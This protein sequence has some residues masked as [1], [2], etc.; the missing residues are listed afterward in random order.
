MI[1]NIINIIIP[2]ITHPS[3]HGRLDNKDLLSMLIV[4]VSLSLPGTVLYFI[5]RIRKKYFLDMFSD[6]SMVCFFTVLGITAIIS[7]MLFVRSIL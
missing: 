2:V 1:N 7:L 6:M 3:H 4:F 5:N